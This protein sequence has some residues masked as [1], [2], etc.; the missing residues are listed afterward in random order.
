[1]EHP[2]HLPVHLGATVPVSTLGYL[3]VH[4]GLGISQPE[5]SI[6]RLLHTNGIIAIVLASLIFLSVYAWVDAFSQLFRQIFPSSQPPF[7]T[8]GYQQVAAMPVPSH[9]QVRVPHKPPP[10]YNFNF[11]LKAIYALLLTLVT[12]LI[13]YFLMF[14][15]KHFELH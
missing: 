15:W 1:M 4:T 8:V 14:V 6:D 10:D 13:A 11:K 7:E 12:I 5:W 9:T 2:V 3:P